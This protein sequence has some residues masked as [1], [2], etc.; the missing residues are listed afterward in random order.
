[1]NRSLEPF[2]ALVA[3]MK[4]VPLLVEQ[5]RWRLVLVTLALVAGIS[6]GLVGARTNTKES[7]IAKLEK[8]GMLMKTSERDLLES[9]EQSRRQAIIFGAAKGAVSAPLTVLGLAMLLSL[10]SWILRARITWSG[11]LTIAT[12]AATPMLLYF[13]IR[14]A[15]AWARPPMSQAD[16][17][18]FVP[19][20]VTL[21]GDG[22]LARAA[23]GI[24]FFRLWAAF[25]IGLGWSAQT[26]WSMKK[27]M[28][29]IAA[30]FVAYVGFAYIGLDAPKPGGAP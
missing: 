20:A 13:V 28:F 29:L 14:V 7:E 19:S 6:G 27:S 3:P 2:A 21:S 24:E 26:R 23:K 8:K 4:W 5:R 11:A 22:P 9:I 17:A 25:L 18:S 16:F 10:V 12:V 15:L 30:L 1:M